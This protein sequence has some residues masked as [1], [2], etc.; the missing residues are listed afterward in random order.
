MAVL[1]RVVVKYGGSS[2]DL[3]IDPSG[4]N[5]KPIS[6]VGRALREL[7]TK[8]V[9]VV[10]PGGG[11]TNELIKAVRDN[12]PPPEG[13]SD[14][15][16]T[17]YKQVLHI[18]SALLNVHWGAELIDPEDGAAK[19]ELEELSVASRGLYII[20]YA[21]SALVADDNLLSYRNSDTLT[22]AIAE[23]LNVPTVVFLKDADGIFRYD[24]KWALPQFKEK[25]ASFEAG[26][27][28]ARGAG[29]HAYPAPV[30]PPHMLVNPPDYYR[31]LNSED[32]LQ[33][34]WRVGAD[35]H[36]DDHLIETDAI[37]YF[38]SSCRTVDRIVIGQV[39]RA[40]SIFEDLASGTPSPDR[41]KCYSLLY[42]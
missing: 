1:D 6:L 26:D 17:L 19:S 36:K 40:S 3:E 23:A 29:E 42:R 41:D 9:V 4:R 37:K 34:V 8:R 33:K 30:P 16:E 20:P 35:D 10:M 28:L 24:Q 27:S 18:N 13:A 12:Y 21:P 15:L 32:M 7:A 5:L 2:L 14:V 11:P 22:L 39:M 31:S 25:R 38:Q